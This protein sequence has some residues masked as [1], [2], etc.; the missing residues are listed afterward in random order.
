MGRGGARA[1]HSSRFTGA[2]GAIAMLR[3]TVATRPDY[4]P[5]HSVL[6]CALLLSSYIGWAEP[7]SEHHAV[8]SFADR[9]VALDDSDPWATSGSGSWR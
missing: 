3:Q 8:T 6:A 4:A 5:A 7:G 1:F 9:A 2:D